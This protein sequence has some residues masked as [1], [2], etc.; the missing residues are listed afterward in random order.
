M[1]LYRVNAG[2][3]GIKDESLDWVRDTK[4]KPIGFV[5]AGLTSNKTFKK[6]YVGENNTLAPR[7]VFDKARWDPPALP[8]MQWDFPV[9]ADQAYLVNLYFAETS[10]SKKK[11]GKRIFDVTIEGLPVLSEYDVVA[12]VGFQV[13]TVK[14][15]QITPS[16]DNIDVD[17]M[18]VVGNPFVN[19]IEII[20]QGNGHESKSWKIN[21]R[22][23]YNVM[24]GPAPETFSL[25]GNFPNPFS[26]ETTVTFNVP[27]PASLSVSVY[28]MLGR[29]VWS[30]QG[31]RVA[32][33][34]DQRVELQLSDLPAGSYLY[35][36]TASRGAQAP[37]TGLFVISK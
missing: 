7:A 12:D 28:D 15:F 33:G 24:P 6:P 23:T 10:T 4:N 13:A 2:G 1:P 21:T 8:E 16:D 31:I 35:R 17:F 32:S 20:H 26:G 34:F 25:T 11:P 29:Q 9:E 19:A 3:G 37:Q 14:S 18:R 27:E 30:Q 5:N 22:Q 36:V